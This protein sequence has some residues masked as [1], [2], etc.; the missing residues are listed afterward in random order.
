M[1]KGYSELTF[2]PK[3]T[4]LIDTYTM[5]IK[6]DIGEDGVD[7]VE[8]ASD[9][10]KTSVTLPISVLLEMAKELPDLNNYPEPVPF[11]EEVTEEEFKGILQ[12]VGGRA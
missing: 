12:D 5:R 3:Q 11:A 9:R 10:H 1:T 7:M 6:G 2:W 8:I 4:D